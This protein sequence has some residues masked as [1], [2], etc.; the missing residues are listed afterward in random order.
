MILAR[1]LF[2]LFSITIFAAASLML[3]IFNYNPY[4]SSLGVF[5]NFYI[6]FALTVAGIFTLLIFYSKCK[7]KKEKNHI[8][9]FWPSVRQASLV[10]IAISI[11]LILEGIKILDWWVGGPLAISTVLLELFFQT[12]PISKKRLN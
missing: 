8:Q 6:S 2:F 5:I 10:A 1:N 4:K 3:D 11:L 7:F 12:A 9:F